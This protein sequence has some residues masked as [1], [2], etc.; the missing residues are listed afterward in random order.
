MLYE[1]T[2]DSYGFQGKY[3]VKG[4]TV[5]IAEG[6]NVP[7]HFSPVGVKPP[8]AP[9]EPEPTTFSAVNKAREEASK[10]HNAGM[11]YDPTKPKPKPKRI[12]RKG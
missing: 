4:E 10:L 5:E 3:W 1:A 2:C 12:V 11:G 9:A 6:E 8:P 7:K